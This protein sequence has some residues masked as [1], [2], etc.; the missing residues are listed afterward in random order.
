MTDRP[1][2]LQQAI[3]YFS[4]KDVAHQYLVD[5]RWSDGVVCPKCGG[6]EHSYLTTRKT[7]KCKACKKQFSVKVGTIFE[8]SPIGLDKWLSAVWMIAN[9]K[10]GISSLEI[11]RA[12]GVTQ[13]TAWFML[14]RIRTAMQSGTF[15]KLNG[16]I[17]AD[18]TYIGGKA[19]NM[20]KWERLQSGIQGRGTVGKAIVFGV[21]Q[22]NTK[23]QSSK[24]KV[25]VVKNIKR[26]TLQPE[27]RNSVEAGS[28]VFTD[29]LKSYEGL[30]NEFIHQ[31]ID[32]ATEY[33]RDNV[34]TNGIENYWSLFK[35]ALRGT[36]VSCD[37]SHLFR[38]LD[39]QTFRFNNRRDTDSMR[40]STVLAM[41]AGK[42]LTYAELTEKES[43]KQLRLFR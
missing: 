34:H 5:L 16:E 8:N 3:V 20:H 1:Q 38:Y 31:S 32:H 39:E 25:K 28:S 36:Y 21:L 9:A 19:E 37:A 41:V 4:D 2:T 29:A 27:I 10:N 26:K 35:R 14:H 11:H 6:L 42:R 17:E 7:W 23:D 40:F 30:Q 18:E 13:K 43:Y 33:V 15:E 22:R 12:L 24:V